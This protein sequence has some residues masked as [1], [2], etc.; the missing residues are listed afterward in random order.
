MPCPTDCNG[1]RGGYRAG[2]DGTCLICA[3]AST[4]MADPSDA[5]P[6]WLARKEA[7]LPFDD[8]ADRKPP[9]P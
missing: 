3:G 8:P 2:P 9:T 5:V 6:G 7:G 4:V 1:G